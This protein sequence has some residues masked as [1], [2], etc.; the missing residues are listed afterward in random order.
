MLYISYLICIILSLYIYLQFIKIKK[1]KKI[2]ESEKNL[3]AEV[4]HDLKSP[5]RAQVNMLNLLLQGYFGELNPKQY[6]M[7]KLLSNSSHYMS[8]LI[9]TLVT[10]YK[11]DSAKLKLRKTKFDIAELTRTIAQNNYYLAKDRQ[12]NIIINCEQKCIVLADKLQIERVIF[13]LLSNAITY[14]FKNSDIIININQN[15]TICEFSVSNKSFPINKKELK[16]IFNKYSK[17]KNSKYNKGSTG[18]GLYTSKKIINLHKGEIHAKY[19][20]DGVFTVSFKINT[21]PVKN[22][23]SSKISH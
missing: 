9:G 20:P 1:Y 7:L 23:L 6:E 21:I 14:G 5:T 4:T 2:N 8:N 22:H 15:K 12:Q 19:L 16:Q 11:Y 18:L 13:N 3:V 10:S 17:T